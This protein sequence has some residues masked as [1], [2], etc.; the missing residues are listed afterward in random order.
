[1]GGVITSQLSLKWCVCGDFNV[2][3]GKEEH[4]SRG[5][6]SRSDDS[7]HFNKFIKDTL[8]IGLSLC[9]RR[10]IWFRG[11]GFSMSRLDRFFTL[12]DRVSSE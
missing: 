3:R 1:M 11:N 6:K 12:E 10:F 2:L 7:F 4:K 5:S 8:L 9:S